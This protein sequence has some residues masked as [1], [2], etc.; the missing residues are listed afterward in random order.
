MNSIKPSESVQNQS[1]PP[2]HVLRVL[3]DCSILL[4]SFLA[5]YGFREKPKAEEVKQIDI[6]ERTWSSLGKAERDFGVNE[7]L[8]SCQI[9]LKLFLPLSLGEHKLEG[10]LLHACK[11]LLAL[12]AKRATTFLFKNFGEHPSD[13]LRGSKR[14]HKAQYIRVLFREITRISNHSLALT[15]HAMDVGASTPFRWAFEEREKLLE[16]YFLMLSSTLSMEDVSSSNSRSLRLDCK[17]HTL[18]AILSQ[19]RRPS[20]R[21]SKRFIISGKDAKMLLKR[22]KKEFNYNMERAS[23]NSNADST[24]ISHKH[25]LKTLLTLTPHC[26]NMVR[27]SINKD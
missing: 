13:C 1:L 26:Q 11:V 27:H 14:S 6:V 16:F 23:E 19:N 5:Q 10:M 12:N 4:F 3:F 9:I 20:P 22:G 18:L 15:T 25:V 17:T 8:G 7:V 21:I 24:T 2:E